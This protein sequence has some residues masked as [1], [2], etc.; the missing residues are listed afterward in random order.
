MVNEPWQSATESRGVLASLSSYIKQA[1]QMG[2]GGN[3]RHVM[4]STDCV[5]KIQNAVPIQ[6]L[7]LAANN[8][9]SL[10]S[11][12]SVHR[13]LKPRYTNMMY[14]YKNQSTVSSCF[15]RNRYFYFGQVAPIYF[16]VRDYIMPV[17]QLYN[18]YYIVIIVW[19]VK[20]LSS[21]GA[22]RGGG[23]AGGGEYPP[24]FTEKKGENMLVHHAT[25]SKILDPLPL[26]NIGLHTSSLL[27]F[28]LL[29]FVL[30]M[31]IV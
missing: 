1:E 18:M 13:K 10:H 11:T 25:S 30:F 24:P 15:Y 29:L 26:V 14:W 6:I 31:R 20:L 28:F 9:R 4:G 12:S 5:N 7:T 19:A 22:D 27:V 16:L 2:S 3:C 17:S 23:R 21:I 8:R